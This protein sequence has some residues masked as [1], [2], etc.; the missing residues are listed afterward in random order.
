MEMLLTEVG[1]QVHVATGTP[2]ACDFARQHPLDVLLT[3]L[4]LQAGD[5]GLQVLQGVRALQ[6]GLRAVLITGDT[7]PDRLRQAQSAGVPLLH[8]PV[9][10]KTLQGVLDSPDPR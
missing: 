8:K 1:C 3:D 9:T 10:L 7:A 2:Q 4:R 6:P 5:D